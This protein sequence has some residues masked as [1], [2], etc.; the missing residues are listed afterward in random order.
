MDTT[1]F[2]GKK[3]AILGFWLEGKSTL[4]FLLENNFAFDSL[5]VLDMNP[6]SVATP[7]IAVRS[8]QDYLAHLDEFDVIFK[9]AG[10]PYTPEL[11]AQ[12]DKILTQMQFFFQNYKGKV[13]A[14]TA[15]KG[16]STMTSLVY[17]MLKDAGLNVKLVGNIGK[18]VLEEIDFDQEYDYVVAELSSFMLEDLEPHTYISVLGHLFP[19]HMDWHGSIDA[20]YQAKF[21]ILK[22]SEHNFILTKTA[23]DFDLA[24]KYHNIYT[25]GIDGETSRNNGYF[26]HHLQELFPTED[27][28]LPGDHNLQ[29]ISLVI[30]IWLFLQI[31]MSSI[32]HTVKTFQWLPHRLQL[33]GEY[34]GIRFYD[35]AISTTPDS[36][37]EAIKTFWSEIWTLFLGGTDRGF[38]FWPLMQKVKEIW[39]QN[40][41]FFP[42]TWEKMAKL[43]GKTSVNICHAQSMEEAITFAY[44]HTPE[45]KI[46]LLSTACPYGLW[47]NFEEKGKAFAEEAQK[48]ANLH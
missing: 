16:K 3:I 15:S 43:L 6:Q 41:V 40:L 4:N 44:K 2:A 26:I 10:V 24:Q 33:I 21:N 31:P 46:C 13:I 11:L 17:A 37:I 1:C 5:T 20:Y 39:I 45:G 22:N 28:L 35:D 48:Q 32:Q 7:G 8:G 36:T 30:A 42:Q 34:Q 25:Y 27:R 12:K 14:I 23:Q 18:P 47:K 29:N 38:D 9:S 19:V